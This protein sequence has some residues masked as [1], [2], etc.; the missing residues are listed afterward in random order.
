MVPRISSIPEGICFRS[1]ILARQI[2]FG[3]Y[4]VEEPV[5]AN[6]II[7]WGRNPDE[8]YWPVGRQVRERVEEGREA[9]HY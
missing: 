9:H 6:C 7:L 2:T 1:R 8:S 4:P 5:N 3:R